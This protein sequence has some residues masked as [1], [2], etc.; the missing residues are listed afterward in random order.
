MES[1]EECGRADRELT[2][3]IVCNLMVCDECD[4]EHQEQHESEVIDD[5]D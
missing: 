3:C 1:C 5:D 4:P 2:L